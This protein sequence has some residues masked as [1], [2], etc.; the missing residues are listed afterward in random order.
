M[1][2]VLENRLQLRHN[3]ISVLLHKLKCWLLGKYLGNVTSNQFPINARDVI[4]DLAVFVVK[5][6]H[7][8][9]CT[10]SSTIKVC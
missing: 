1:E 10:P 6:Y 4:S 2:A 3:F 8:K 7:V 9:F 5:L